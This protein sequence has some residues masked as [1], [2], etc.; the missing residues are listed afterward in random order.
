MLNVF[1]DESGDQLF[2]R[3]SLKATDATNEFIFTVTLA[4]SLLGA[5]RPRAEEQSRKT[6]MYPLRN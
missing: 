1:F 6:S 3:D 5:W 4:A 2:L